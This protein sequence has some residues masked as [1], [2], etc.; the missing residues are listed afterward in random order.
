[1]ARHGVAGPGG[2]RLGGAWQIMAGEA[3][4]GM[5]WRGN[6]WQARQGEASLVEAGL[7]SSGQAGDFTN[8]GRFLWCLLDSIWSLVNEGQHA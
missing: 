1:M 7:G 6:S 8:D 5:A 4:H 3:R 2:A